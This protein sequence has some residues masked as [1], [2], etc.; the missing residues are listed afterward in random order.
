M[1]ENECNKERELVA[2][3]EKTGEQNRMLVSFELG[4]NNYRWLGQVKER[5]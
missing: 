5:Q 4:D 2:E 3:E 1:S